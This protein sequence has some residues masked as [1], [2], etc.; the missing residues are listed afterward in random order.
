MA[1]TDA[2]RQQS[3]RALAKALWKDG[4]LT[5]NMH[6]GDLKNAVV[7]VDQGL[8]SLVG[9]HLAT[10]TIEVALNKLLPEPFKSTATVAQ[11]GLL[12]AYVAMK[13]YGVL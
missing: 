11:K 2:D 6:L 12:L 10:D 3:A 5:A 1:M 7:A 13:R 4:A 9:S 8:D